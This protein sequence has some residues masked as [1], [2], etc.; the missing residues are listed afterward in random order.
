MLTR[1][2]GV[3]VRALDVLAPARYR[4]ARRV[5]VAAVLDVVRRVVVVPLGERAGR[6]GVGGLDVCFGGDG[7]GPDVER[8]DCYRVPRRSRTL[9]V[10]GREGSAIEPLKF[11]VLRGC[12]RGLPG[13][14]D[15]CR[16][17]A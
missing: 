8:N 3:G 7:V 11:D 4:G 15:G 17:G 13:S 12:G 10:E 9:L 14:P 6:R 16:D 2:E 1:S 5:V